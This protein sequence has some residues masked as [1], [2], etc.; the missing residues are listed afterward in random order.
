M[1]IINLKK[2]DEF[3][4]F[5]RIVN[6]RICSTGHFDAM[7]MTAIAGDKFLYPKLNKIV[8]FNLFSHHS[9]DLENPLLESELN[10][11]ENTKESISVINPGSKKRHKARCRRNGRNELFQ[12]K[13]RGWHFY[14]RVVTIFIPSKVLKFCGIR[15]VEQNRAWRE[16]FGLISIILAIGAIVIYIS[17]IFTNTA[18]GYKQPKI[19][20]EAGESLETR[21]W[22]LQ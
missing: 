3:V 12:S 22:R 17:F 10:T 2:I 13:V 11:I 9:P 14:C 18:C 5:H 21:R 4:T 16:K 6:N 20:H 19:L 1:D 7:V 15:T 8:P